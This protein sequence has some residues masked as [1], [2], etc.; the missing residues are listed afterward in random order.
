MLWWRHQMGTFS[1]L[2][3]LCVGNSPVAGEFPAHRPVTRSFD[4][5]FDLRLNK[6]LSK[7]LWGWWF[8]TLSCSLW[9]HCNRAWWEGVY[10]SSLLCT[11]VKLYIWKDY[12]WIN[13]CWS[14]IGWEDYMINMM[15]S[16]NVR[17]FRVTGPLCGKFT[18][19]R[20]IPHTKAGDAELWWFFYLLLNKRLSKRWW[21]WW[22]ETPMRPLWRQCNEMAAS[23]RMEWTNDFH[24]L[25]E[26]CFLLGDEKVG[27]PERGI[28]SNQTFGSYNDICHG[29]A[30][31]HNVPDSRNNSHF[32]LHSTPPNWNRYIS[33]VAWSL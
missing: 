22:F 9:H 2:L 19:P 32:N 26:A 17:I 5:F 4:V 27:I 24:S 30:S 12:Y 28:Y 33:V 3:D 23:L 16:S 6:R 13:D 1:A 29:Q 14:L 25:P 18:G 31:A 7:Q 8:E 20:W 21:G 10:P 11:L 15:T